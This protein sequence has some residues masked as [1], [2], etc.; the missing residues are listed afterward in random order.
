MDISTLP[1]N[2]AIGII[3]DGSGVRLVPTGEHLNHVGTVHATVLY[4]VAEAAT[5]QFLIERFSNL[6][7]SYVAVLRT[8]T[9]K[10]RR[11]ASLGSD[12]GGI[13]QAS[14]DKVAKFEAALETRGRSTI[15]IDVSVTQAE[16]ELF[17]G[18]FCWFASRQMGS[19]LISVSRK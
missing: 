16:T 9:V 18:V 12:I 11:P 15:E 17:T 8:S 13:A 5:G 4:G 10:Y 7:D 3:A 1:F 2:N 19:G 14:D 6:A